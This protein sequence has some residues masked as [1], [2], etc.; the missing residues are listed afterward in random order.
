MLLR[1]LQPRRYIVNI[2]GG[3]PNTEQIKTETTVTLSDEQ[4]DVLRRIIQGK[5]TFFS[6]SA[7]T[8]K[9]VLLREII[10]QLG[11]ASQRLGITASTGIAAINIGGATLHSWAGIGIGAE[12]AKK[13]AGMFLGQPKFEKVLERWRRLDTVSM[14]DGALFDKL[15]VLSGDFFQLPPVPN[16]QDNVIIPPTFAFDSKTWN[17]CIGNPIT[18]TRV[19]RQK[20]QGFSIQ[21]E[22]FLFS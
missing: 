15:L 14:V 4:R 18:L 16:R 11:G 20:D 6:G 17:A 12:S 22:L 19:F 10:N 1:V 3:I 5:S 7:G 21:S 9:S 13:L 2:S 8:G